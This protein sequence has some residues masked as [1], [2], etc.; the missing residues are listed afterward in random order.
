[1]KNSK[2]YCEFRGCGEELKQ[3]SLHIQ[4]GTLKKARKMVC[5]KNSK[6]CYFLVEDREPSKYNRMYHS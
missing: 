4:T 5:K 3:E 6:H 1:M 2:A